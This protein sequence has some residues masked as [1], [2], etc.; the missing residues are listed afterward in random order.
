M[1]RIGSAGARLYLF[2]FL[3]LFVIGLVLVLTG[4]DLD[5]VDLWLDDRAGLFDVI[6]SRLFNVLW[7]AVLALCLFTVVGGLWQKFVSP[8][9][10]MDDAADFVVEPAGEDEL[11][12]E[13]AKPVGWGCMIVALIVGYFAWFGM[14]G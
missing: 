9:S 8:R 1:F 13:P 6:G 10:Q 12:E 7:G 2:L 5:K 11:V 3:L 14:T 4:F